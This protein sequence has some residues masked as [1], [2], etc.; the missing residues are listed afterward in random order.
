M[1][2]RPGSGGVPVRGK[3]GRSVAVAV[4]PDGD[5]ACRPGVQDRNG[6]YGRAWRGRK[7]AKN[8]SGPSPS[9][10]GRLFDNFRN[11]F[12]DA[13]PHEIVQRGGTKSLLRRN[14]FGFNIT[15]PVKIPRL[16]KAR[17]GTY[18][19]LSYEGVRE[20]ISRTSLQTV[21]TVAERQGDFSQTVDATGNLLPIYDPATTRPNPGFDP[22]QPVSTSNLQYLRD[23]FPGNRIPVEH[24]NATARNALA[25]YPEPNATVGPFNENNFFVNSPETNVANGMI[26]KVDHAI[27]DRHRLS[28]E[29]AYSDGLLGAARYFPNAA[30]PGPSDKDSSSKRASMEYVFTA[31]PQTIN[32]V[33][34][35]AHSQK[36]NTGNPDDVFP[37]YA[38]AGDLGMG[39]AY[40]LSLNTNNIYT[41]TDGISLRAGNH[42]LRFAGQH[43]RYQ[44]NSLWGRYPEGYF[45]FTP[46]LTSLPGIVNTGHGFASFLL[47]LPETR[48]N[49]NVFAVVFSA[50]LHDVLRAGPLRI[51]E[52]PS[53]F[54]R[55][56]LAAIR[57]GLRNTIGNPVSI[58]RS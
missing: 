4:P 31:S 48:R 17:P 19:S 27:N 10:H 47:G 15:G 12:L 55:S 54:C 20:R 37:A 57:R 6:R 51:E 16:L 28:A 58:S 30:N 56:R 40:P 7:Q 14:Q 29:I 34:V 32:T 25:L 8:G 38:I 52:E 36:W 23:P 3:R 11:D 45:R 5:G 26:A 44:V 13:V 43:T 1:S 41:L 46:G 2:L 18:F 42:S 35:E 49:G 24:L 33:S 22:S 50:Q 53:H 9:W 39:R 21:P